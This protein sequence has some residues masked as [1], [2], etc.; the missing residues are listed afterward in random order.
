MTQARHVVVMDLSSGYILV[1]ERWRIG[2]TRLGRVKAQQALTQVE[3]Q[4]SEPWLS[5]RGASF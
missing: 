5:D 2:N 4:E 1:E 3:V